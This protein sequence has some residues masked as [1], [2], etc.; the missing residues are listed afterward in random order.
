[1]S[2][3][4]TGTALPLAALPGSPW[5]YLTAWAILGF[6]TFLLARAVLKTSP[7]CDSEDFLVALPLAL[8]IR[9]TLAHR[10]DLTLLYG[11]GTLTLAITAGA[12]FLW[13]RH[14]RQHR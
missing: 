11:Y 8:G 10:P 5:P 1:M 4:W 3:S 7:S 14:S 2:Y 9:V 13:R 6:G 12:A